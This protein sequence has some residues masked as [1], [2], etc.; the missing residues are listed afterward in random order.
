MPRSWYWPS[1]D[2]RAIL[3]TGSALR[4]GGRVGVVDP[5]RRALARGSDFAGTVPTGAVLVAR[6]Y[7]PARAAATAGV[8]ARARS[9]ARRRPLAAAARGRPERDRRPGPQRPPG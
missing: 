6:H 5:G 7:V 2:P 4:G 3:K 9:R 8:A 1:T